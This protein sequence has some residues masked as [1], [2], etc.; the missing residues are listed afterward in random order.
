MARDDFTRIRVTPTWYQVDG[1]ERAVVFEPGFS[2]PGPRGPNWCGKHGMDMRF[3]LRGPKGVAQFLIFTGWVPGDETTLELYPSGADVGYHARVAQYEDQWGQTDCEYLS[4]PCFY[5][6]SS[7][8]AVDLLD[9]F[10]VMGESVVWEELQEVHD[11]IEEVS[12][13]G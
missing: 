11:R 4:G 1:F 7:L 9:R 5:D 12:D 6:G 2:D 8:A 10:K 13:A 3:L